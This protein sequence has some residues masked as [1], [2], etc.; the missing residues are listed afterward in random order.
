LKEIAI[1]ASTDTMIAEKKQRQR[2]SF[3]VRLAK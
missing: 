1:C 3:S 2:A